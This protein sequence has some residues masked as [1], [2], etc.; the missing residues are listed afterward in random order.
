MALVLISALLLI[1]VPLI[2]IFYAG[3]RMVG[4]VKNSAKGLSLSLLALFVI[5]VIL[6]SIVGVQMG[7]EFS[8]D[9]ES[10]ERIILNTESDTLYVDVIQDDVF[11]TDLKTWQ[12]EFFDLVKMD[13]ETV[14]YGDPVHLYIRESNG[15][16]FEVEIFKSANGESQ[17]KAIERVERM[18]YNWS[19]SDSTAKIELAPYFSSPRSDHFRGQ[20]VE[21]VV[22]VPIGKFIAFNDNVERIYSRRNRAGRTFL[23]GPDELELLN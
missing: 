23:M 1:A 10:S 3:T 18:D 9:H 20:E 8:R 5:G 13:E 17:Q 11:H 16:N 19:V 14:Y 22:R 21:I 12:T 4:A 7:R 2:A 6:A 15:E